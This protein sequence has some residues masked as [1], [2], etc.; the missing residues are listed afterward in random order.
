MKQV[1]L[2]LMRAYHVLSIESIDVVVHSHHELNIVDNDVSNV[3][4]V[5]GMSHGIQNFVILE[6]IG[7]N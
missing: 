5:Y 4:K 2:F 3:V 6:S 1:I 7:N